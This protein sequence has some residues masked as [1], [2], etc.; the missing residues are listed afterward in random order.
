MLVTDWLL[1]DEIDGLVLSREL[2]KNNPSLRTIVITGLPVEDARKQSADDGIF[3]YVS[4]PF[5]F[6]ALADL[7][8]QAAEA[9]RG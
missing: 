7:V 1:K 3:A 5:E 9:P 2:K 6:A 4:K 8:K